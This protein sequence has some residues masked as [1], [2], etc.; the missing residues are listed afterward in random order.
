MAKKKTRGGFSRE[1]PGI[2]HRSIIHALLLLE[3][4]RT[5]RAFGRPISLNAKFTEK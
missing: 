5:I 4:L 1:E 2:D 3:F